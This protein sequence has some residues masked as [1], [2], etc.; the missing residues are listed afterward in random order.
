METWFTSILWPTMLD[1]QSN[2]TF[3]KWNFYDFLRKKNKCPIII[4]QYNHFIKNSR[5][6]T[7]HMITSSIL[8]LTTSILK[9]HIINF[10]SNWGIIIFFLS[11]ALQ[12]FDYIF[13][14]KIF[15]AIL[16]FSISLNVGKL[17][18]NSIGVIKRNCVTAFELRN[19]WDFWAPK[20]NWRKIYQKIWKLI[21]G[22]RIWFKRDFYC[23][24]MTLKDLFS[25][26][27]FLF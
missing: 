14:W 25:K 11:A 20:G 2:I 7:K 16:C 22:Y 15:N 12:H 13:Y 8:Q 21:Q 27:I 24:K 10:N 1:H 26:K 18:A 23:I 4:N 3:E 5:N 6:I 9:C 19:G 17:R